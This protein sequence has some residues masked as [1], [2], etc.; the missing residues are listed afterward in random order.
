[1]RQGIKLSILLAAA[2][3]APL[4]CG[5]EAAEPSR[6]GQ[7]VGDDDL[8]PIEAAKGTALYDYARGVAKVTLSGGGC[9]G[10]RVGR[11]LFVTNNHCYESSTCPQTVFTLGVEKDNARELQKAF[12]CKEVVSRSPDLDYALYRVQPRSV[13][14]GANDDY[15]IVT[16]KKTLPAAGSALFVAGYP[17][18]EDFK[19]MDRS[20]G[21]KLVEGPNQSFPNY[22][23]HS[24][25][26]ISGSSGSS[27][28]EKATGHVVA[29][30]WGYMGDANNKATAM[31]KILE[32]IKTSAPAVYT[33]L[34]V[35]P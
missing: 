26:T 27:V 22:I 19:R 13:Q 17:C 24:C 23:S 25:D 4:A 35:A 31:G 11:D 8:E 32:H 16:L 28:F 5:P 9:T 29:L 3:L 6:T 2:A 30:H 12:V 1:M 34:T 21:C 18:C 20:D 7:I 14:D 10:F 33:E 15:P